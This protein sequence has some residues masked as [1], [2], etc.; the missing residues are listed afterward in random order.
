M[1]LETG[2]PIVELARRKIVWDKL[3]DKLDLQIL[4]RVRSRSIED[5]AQSFVE[6]S[7][8]IGNRVLDNLIKRQDD[9]G[10]KEFGIIMASLSNIHR[11]KQLESGQP[12]DII[13]KTQTMSPKE[14]QAYVAESYANL[15]GKHKELVAPPDVEV[16]KI[17]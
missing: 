5:H 3:K 12:T 7:L 1:L 9:L 14:L 8:H 10:V 13:A 15:L 17:K 11:I 16:E 6:K 2:I 4:E